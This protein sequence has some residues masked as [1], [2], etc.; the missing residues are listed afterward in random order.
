MNTYALQQY[1]KTLE[2]TA[3]EAKRLALE[4]DKLKSPMGDAILDI[5]ATLARHG[6]CVISRAALN[7]VAQ[8]LANVP[9]DE[10]EPWPAGMHASVAAVHETLDRRPA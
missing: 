2:A 5:A 8:L 9:T 1:A 3:A 7:D 4:L 6:L 10:Y